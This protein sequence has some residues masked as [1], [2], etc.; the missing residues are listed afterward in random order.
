MLFSGE[1]IEPW[2]DAKRV[3]KFVVIGRNLPRDE[4][5]NAFQ[6][7]FVGAN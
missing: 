6:A 1:T 2:G 7:C 4:I 3:N 5:T